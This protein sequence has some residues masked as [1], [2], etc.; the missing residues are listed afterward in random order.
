MSKSQLFNATLMLQRYLVTWSFNNKIHLPGELRLKHH[1]VIGPRVKTLFLWQQ[2]G[3]DLIVILTHG[4]IDHELTIFT[5][6][7]IS[8]FLMIVETNN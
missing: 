2:G 4:L 6:S 8:A 5:M 1:E 7:Q 3:L